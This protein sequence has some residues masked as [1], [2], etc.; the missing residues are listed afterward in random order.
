MKGTLTALRP[1]LYRCV[2]DADRSGAARLLSEAAEAEGFRAVIADLLEP[3][4][5]EVGERFVKD[6]LSLAQGYVAGKIAEDLLARLDA[7]PVHARLARDAGTAV[8][9]NA[10]D[11]YHALG[12]RMVSTFLRIEGWR[13]EDLGNDVLAEAFVDKAEELGARVIGVSAMM[14]T[15]ALNI[16]R[17]R[18]ELAR[19]GLERRI[20]LA[21]GGAVF[22]MRPELV[23][24]V[25]GDGTCRTAMEAPA[26]FADLSSRAE[27]A[28]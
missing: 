24:E 11:D 2:I 18:E 15:N 22:I 16:A 3:T 9:G 21:V 28:R 1:E 17:I 26:L 4:L 19:R 14:L 12:R 10:E 7:D 13:V 23:A 5:R 8:I 6:R 25:G 20:K 27:A